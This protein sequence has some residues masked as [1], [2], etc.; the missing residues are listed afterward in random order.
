MMGNHTSRDA[1]S[2]LTSCC[3]DLRKATSSLTN[4]S[5]WPDISVG[6]VAAVLDAYVRYTGALKAVLPGMLTEC[7]EQRDLLD[8][9][10][11]ET[12]GLLREVVV[13]ELGK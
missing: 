10:L 8:K 5:G 2:S 12:E 6:K 13:A 4:G 7:R 1:L 3:E 9:R 11:Q